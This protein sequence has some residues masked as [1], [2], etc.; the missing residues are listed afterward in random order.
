[1]KLERGKDNKM[2]VF[3]VPIYYWVVGLGLVDQHFIIFMFGF[4]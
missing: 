2:K 3:W 4:D 1:L